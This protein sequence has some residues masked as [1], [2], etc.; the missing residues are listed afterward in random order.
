[1]AMRLTHQTALQIY[2]A[3]YKSLPPHDDTFALLRKARR[4]DHVLLAPAPYALPEQP[5][6]SCQVD[7]SPWWHDIESNGAGLEDQM[8]VDGEEHIGKGGRLCHLCW[9]KSRSTA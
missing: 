4:L 8:D 9:F 3:A 5:C 6:V 1:M 7:V 2:A